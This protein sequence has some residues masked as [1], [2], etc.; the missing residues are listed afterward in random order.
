MTVPRYWAVVPAAGVGRRF[1][2]DIPKQYLPLR[3]RPVLQHTLERL[4]ALP[5][6]VGVVVAIGATDR[7]WADLQLALPCPLEVVPGGA[8]RVDSVLRAARHLVPRLGE[9]DW[10]LVHDAARPCVRPDDVIRLMDAVRDHP[11]GGLLGAPVRDTMK[12]VDADGTVRA[13]VDRGRLWHAYTPQ[14]FRAPL[15]LAALEGAV[16]EG[17]PVT[18]EASAM[19]AA[20]HAPRM[21]QGH[22]DNLKITRR[23]DLALA[24][25]FL[26]R[27]VAE[28]VA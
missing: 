3:G 13:T 1:G 21:V 28:G 12:D 22:A 4:A 9:A 5:G 10:L 24:E 16:A 11:C 6:L 27:Q 14:L 25:F 17:R 23:E 20:G 26:A 15:L 2:A 19:E 8:E 7:W 18:D